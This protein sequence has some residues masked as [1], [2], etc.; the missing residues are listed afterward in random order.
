MTASDYVINAGGLESNTSYPYTAE[1]GPC[2]FKKAEVVASISSW[3]YATQNHDESLFQQNLVSYGPL[4]V[5]VDAAR[6]QYYQSGVMTRFQ[7]DIITILD[8]CVQAVG[9]NATASTP[10]YMVRNSWGFDW[11]M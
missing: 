8:H 2:H 6:W 7:C 3:Q 5:C 1:N 10:Y 4:S 9:F 11:G